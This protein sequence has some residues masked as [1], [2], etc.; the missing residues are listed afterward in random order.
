MPTT[1]RALL[2]AALVLALGTA[3]AKKTA[4][5]PAAAPA[6]AAGAN[7]TNAANAPGTTT[8]F[9]QP[10]PADQSEPAKQ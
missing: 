2:L 1:S 3:C 10:K 9:E 5:E 4:E 6:P 8:T 7:D